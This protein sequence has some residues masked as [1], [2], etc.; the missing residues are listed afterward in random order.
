LA[1]FAGDSAI[2]VILRVEVIRDECFDAT[3]LTTLE[4]KSLISFCLK[5][6]EGSLLK[7]TPTPLVDDPA[8]EHAGLLDIHGCECV[9]ILLDS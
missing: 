4:R 1:F 6:F 8:L 3:L 2:V 7:K 9:H 5:D